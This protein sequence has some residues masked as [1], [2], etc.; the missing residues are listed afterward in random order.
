MKVLEFN[1]KTS[2]EMRRFAFQN[3]EDADKLLNDIIA[4]R[5]DKKDTMIITGIGQVMLINPLEILELVLKEAHS[6]NN[7]DI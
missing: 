6:E 1:Y 7:N 3:D 5:N 2:S 4:A